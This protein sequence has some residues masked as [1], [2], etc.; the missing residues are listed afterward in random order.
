MSGVTLR[1]TPEALD[2]IERI[3]AYIARARRQ[4][5][6]RAYKVASLIRV[7]INHLQLFPLMGRPGRLDGTR[8]LI[9]SRLPYVAIYVVRGNEVLI[10]RVLHQAQQWPPAEDAEQE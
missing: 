6:A 7:A 5:P 2:D 3:H 8:E 9:V 10:Q 1:F 4:S